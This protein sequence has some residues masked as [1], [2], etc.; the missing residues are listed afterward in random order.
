VRSLSDKALME[1]LKAGDMGALEVLYERYR[2]MVE[3][4]IRRVIPNVSSADV[5][6]LTHDVFIALVRATPTFDF[7]K[8]LKP[9]LYGIAVNKAAGDKRRG[10]VHRNL[11]DKHRSETEALGLH[12]V[13]SPFKQVE[14][15]HDL[16]QAFAALP[17]EQHDVMILHAV[18]G[19]T[20]EEI[21]DIL[22]IKVKTVWT[23]LHR[24]RRK[25]SAKMCPGKKG[26]HPK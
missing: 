16:I 3:A 9:W 20:G 5:E 10:W 26:L 18:E 7:F 19:F 14:I 12:T 15:R 13:E 8:R 22:G 21:A 2:D 25:L 17:K 1:Q 23:R 4:A 11:L 6:E 24:A